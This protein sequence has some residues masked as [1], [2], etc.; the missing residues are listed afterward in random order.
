M[1]CHFCLENALLHL[2]VLLEGEFGFDLHNAW[3]IVTTHSTEKTRWIYRR[4]DGAKA[5][6]G[7]RTGWNLEVRMIKHVVGLR[8]KAERATFEVH[9][10]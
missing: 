3:R 4:P 7:D 5:R 9:W 2:P 6:R 8:S 10:N 1:D